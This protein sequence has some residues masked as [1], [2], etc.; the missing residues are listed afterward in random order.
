MDS[1]RYN[2]ATFCGNPKVSSGTSELLCNAKSMVG[3]A[4]PWL[5]SARKAPSAFHKKCFCANY[6]TYV[7]YGQV[8]VMYASS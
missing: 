8:K 7:P 3:Q 6:I 5:S 4:G 2:E 1:T